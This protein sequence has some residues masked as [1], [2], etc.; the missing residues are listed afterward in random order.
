MFAARTV[1]FQRGLADS[2]KCCTHRPSCRVF[3]R[4]KLR[5][6]WLDDSNA[7]S[8]CGK[9]LRWLRRHKGAS[10]Q[11]GAAHSQLW[12]R[13]CC[14]PAVRAKKSPARHSHARQ[15][16][17]QHAC[18]CN[19][20]RWRGWRWSHSVVSCGA[21]AAASLRP[22]QTGFV[23]ATY[24]FAPELCRRWFTCTKPWLAR[25]LAAPRTRACAPQA[26]GRNAAAS[27][28]AALHVCQGQRTA[29]LVASGSSTAAYYRARRGPVRWKATR[30]SEAPEGAKRVEEPPERSRA[31]ST[32]RL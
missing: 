30:A 28:R 29:A 13:T 7:S 32:V 22:R 8:V 26:A 10:R 18:L 16:C 15:R 21:L 17:A 1:F 5:R 4:A 23:S 9:A 25:P 14:G 27:C 3:L 6:A 24:A 2:A 31:C 19:Q 12:L 20:A 11:R